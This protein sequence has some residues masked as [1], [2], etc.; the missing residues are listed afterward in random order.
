M[1]V[2][3]LRRLSL[4]TCSSKRSAQ[5]LHLHLLDLVGLRRGDG[6]QQA[7]GGVEGAIGVVAG[8]RLLV[9]PAVAH[10][11]QFADQDCVRRGR[12]CVRK[13]SFHASHISLSSPAASHWASGLFASERSSQQYVAFFFFFVGHHFVQLRIPR[14]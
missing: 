10:I 13:T 12:A 4:R 9:R 8:E 14:T 2:P 7:R 6:R 5:Q 3:A 11:A 1:A